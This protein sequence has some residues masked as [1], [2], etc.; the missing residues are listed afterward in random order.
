[1]FIYLLLLCRHCLNGRGRK[2]K[3]LGR[4]FGKTQT[5]ILMLDLH[6]LS[7]GASPTFSGLGV[8]ERVWKTASQPSTSFIQQ[9]FIEHWLWDSHYP[10][11]Q[12]YYNEQ[13]VNVL[14]FSHKT[15]GLLIV[16]IQLV[17]IIIAIV[18]NHLF[19]CLLVQRLKFN[20]AFEMSRDGKKWT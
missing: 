13:K 14:S 6:L 16:V 20:C 17:I 7:Q 18:T 3:C 5:E 15:L 2:W 1:M 11:C 8:T 19:S 4:P 12:A 9:P 10:R